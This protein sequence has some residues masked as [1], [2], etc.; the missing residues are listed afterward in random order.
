MDINEYHAHPAISSSNLRLFFKGPEYYKYYVIDGN[1]QADSAAFHKG[2]LA[3]TAVLEPHLL[4]INYDVADQYIT[5]KRCKAWKD[6]AKKAKNPLLYSEYH[7]AVAMVEAV[8]RH[9]IAGNIFID[10]KAE[11]SFFCRHKSGLEIKA[12][13]DFLKDMGDG[14]LLM[15]DY[16]TTSGQLDTRKLTYAARDYGYDL[17][18]AFHKMV[19]ES[20]ADTIISNV[21]HVVQSTEPPFKVKVVAFPDKSLVE[22]EEKVNEGLY[23]LAEAINSDSWCDSEH[24]ETYIF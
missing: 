14:T 7:T 1:K 8:E 23:A 19:V 22:A 3:H 17:Q 21:L 5:D 10:G 6:F 18:A 16:K 13:P 12:R 15:A 20:S 2:T 24:I 4:D 11:Q 9:S